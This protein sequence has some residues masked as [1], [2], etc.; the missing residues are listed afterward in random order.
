MNDNYYDAWYLRKIIEIIEYD[1][2]EALSLFDSYLREYPKDCMT[3]PFYITAL[4]ALGKVDEA[5]KEIILSDE[6]ARR[7]DTVKKRKRKF[8]SELMAYSKIKL[9]LF[10]KQYQELY[11][12]INSY[13]YELDNISL[14]HVLFFCKKKLGL[15]S[16]KGNVQGKSYM[17]R[18]IYAYSYNDFLS[19]IEKH[20][21]LYVTD[22][23]DC[24]LNV[25]N[26]DFPIN[27][28]LEEL[29]KYIPSDKK[30]FTGFLEDKYYF[31]YDGC[32]RGF[33][34]NRLLDYFEVVAFH[35]TGDLITMYPVINYRDRM[36]YI[37]LNYLNDVKLKRKNQIEKFNDRYKRS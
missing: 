21:A 4:L 12:F 37:D 11:D 16:D 34:S 28:V 3:Y 32:G 17:F 9:M 23:Q 27:E 29:K 33:N 18:Q 35:D 13:E 2:Y 6:L 15:I 31:K 1:P 10:N 24:K 14:E 20:L 26:V 7:D 36:D 22:Y 5:K 30:I 19:H 8:Y 25:F